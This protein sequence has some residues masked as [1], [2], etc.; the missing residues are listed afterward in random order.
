MR[1]GAILAVG[2]SC[3]LARDVS[4]AAKH[5]D[6]GDA[7]I[8]P[9]F[10][11]AHAHLELTCYRGMLPQG[12]LWPWIQELVRLRAAPEAGGREMTAAADGA[13]ES[14]AHGITCVG[15]I[16]RTGAAISP[17][18]NSP[19]RKTC[20]IE[21]ISQARDEPNDIASLTTALDDCDG[22]HQTDRLRVGIS[23]H[24]PY[25][26][27]ADDL[28]GAIRLGRERNAP[29]TMH[30]LET[31]E[32]AAWLRGEPSSITEFLSRFAA[33]NSAGD[34]ARRVADF[35]R[36]GAAF[37]PSML[38]A[39]VNHAGDRDIAAIAA[40]GASVVW[41]P[42]AHAY[43]GHARHR[44][45]DML[46]AGINVCIGTD[47]APCVATL[48]VLD[49]LRAIRR[50]DPDVAAEVLLRM[51]TTN[52]ARALGRQGQIG[53]LEPGMRADFVVSTLDNAGRDPM[54]ELFSEDSRVAQTFIDGE[55]VWPPSGQK[56][57]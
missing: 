38:L 23:P 47:S 14:L 27:T 22:T 25:T 44:W 57:E 4:A 20:F 50:Q 36:S 53:A 46:A 39:H 40:G 16:S 52:G 15:D 54:H 56:S 9:G 51:G 33:P 45:R 34:A 32:E 24:A 11:N 43:Y 8:T 13:T 35:L 41:C 6:F 10:V 37:T 1:E 3:D 55:L 19:I 17:L 31:P 28:A 7:L 26:V 30:Y 12:P 48:S 49:E 5:V 29:M 21:L 2:R 18:A 42:R